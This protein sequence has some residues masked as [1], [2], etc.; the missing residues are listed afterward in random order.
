MAG[1]RPQKREAIKKKKRRQKENSP[2]EVSREKRREK[3]NNVLDPNGL[4]K[5]QRREGENW[6]KG[7][8]R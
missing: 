1:E 2:G 3:G 6:W 4:E 7:R 5:D 8:D